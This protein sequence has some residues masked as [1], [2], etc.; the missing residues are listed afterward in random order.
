MFLD[1]FVVPGYYWSNCQLSQ[2]SSFS[3]FFY[4]FKETSFRPIFMDITYALCGT[5]LSSCSIGI[6]IGLPTDVFLL[7]YIG[8]Q[9][10]PVETSIL[11]FDLSIGHLAQLLCHPRTTSELNESELALVYKILCVRN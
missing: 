5:F 1:L 10:L 9:N 2:V 4:I 11:D 6:L 8:A 7:R 3:Q